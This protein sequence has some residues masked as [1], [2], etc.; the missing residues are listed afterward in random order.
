MASPT[1]KSSATRAKKAAP[2]KPATRVAVKQSAAPKKVRSLQLAKSDRPFMSFSFT[3]DTLYWLILCV[4]VLLLGIWILT[5]TI[6]V[7]D[8]YNQIDA[9]DQ[10]QTQQPIVHDKPVKK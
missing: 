6:R 5:L 3:T 10:A 2:K 9:S 7:Q 8:I 4:V 1:K